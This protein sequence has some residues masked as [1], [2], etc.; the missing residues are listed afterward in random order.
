VRKSYINV[1]GADNTFA[2]NNDGAGGGGAGGSIVLLSQ[3]TNL[4]NITIL[5]KGGQGGSDNL[6]TDAGHGP[7][8]GGSAGVVFTSAATS[9]SSVIA[10]GESGFTGGSNGDFSFGST[11]GTQF[12]GLVRTTVTQGDVPNITQASNCT[13]LPLPVELMQFAAKAVNQQVQLTWTTASEKN[14]N[15]F[16]VERSLDGQSF[17]Q[18]GTQLG[19][20]TSSA[21]HRYAFTDA[22]VRQYSGLLYYRLRQVDEDGTATYSPVRTVVLEAGAAKFTISPNPATGSVTLDLTSLPA[23]QYHVSFHDVSGRSVGAEQVIGGGQTTTVNVASFPAGVYILT[24]QG[25]QQVQTQ[26]LVK[27]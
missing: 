25:Q 7:G 18:L 24:V 5:A 8:G 2:I 10:S 15:R 14:N 27:Y 13:A 4:A 16:E 26:R 19:Q 1:N 12:A 3:S 20:G 21:A 17:T 23:G 22:N 9:T 6:G 11:V